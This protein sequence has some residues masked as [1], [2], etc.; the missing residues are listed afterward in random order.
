MWWGH[1]ATNPSEPLPKVARSERTDGAIP[2]RTCSVS[3]CTSGLTVAV[4]PPR[5]PTH[6][7]S[8]RTPRSSAEGLTAGLR[9]MERIGAGPETEA[10]DYVSTGWKRRP[11][12]VHRDL[13]GL[14]NT[15]RSGSS[16]IHQS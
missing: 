5:R 13:C 2:P 14:G 10:T 1:F 8:W 7:R 4:T 15:Q 16:D 12:S 6:F 3:S 11:L 9:E